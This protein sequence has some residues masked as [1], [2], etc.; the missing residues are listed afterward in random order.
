[1]KHIDTDKIV[2]LPHFILI[3]CTMVVIFASLTSY[4]LGQS[5]NRNNTW[6]VAPLKHHV[7]NIINC[8]SGYVMYDNIKYS[9][10]TL[11]TTEDSGVF[12]VYYMSRNYDSE[13]YRVIGVESLEFPY[14]AYLILTNKGGM[15]PEGAEIRIDSCY[16]MHIKKLY[17]I[18]E[19]LTTPIERL[20]SKE[21]EIELIDDRNDSYYIVLGGRKDYIRCLSLHKYISISDDICGSRYIGSH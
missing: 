9:I 19:P 18:K 20:I 2:Y 21:D 14:K 4:C 10:D 8:D 3:R 12:H 16:F 15:C 1:M 7:N 17:T 13:R 11:N 6:H 5:L